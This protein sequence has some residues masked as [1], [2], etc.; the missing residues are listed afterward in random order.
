VKTT[1]NSTDYFSP[2]IN[3]NDTQIIY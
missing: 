1:T 3:A 2:Q